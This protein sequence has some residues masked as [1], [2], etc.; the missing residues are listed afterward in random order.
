MPVTTVTGTIL[1][2]TTFGSST[3]SPAVT[4]PKIRCFRGNGYC[5]FQIFYFLRVLN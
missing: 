4:S 2:V 1:P 5:N 3:E